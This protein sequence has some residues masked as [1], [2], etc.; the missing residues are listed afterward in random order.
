MAQIDET[1]TIS[2]IT[3][4]TDD[5]E[6]AEDNREL[7]KHP[8]LIQKYGRLLLDLSGIVAEEVRLNRVEALAFFSKAFSVIVKASVQVLRENR[9]NES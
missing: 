4:S 7:A 1:R 6:L 5:P 2:W 8:E 3:G 9:K